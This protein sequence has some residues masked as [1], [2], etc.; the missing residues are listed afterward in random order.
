MRLFHFVKFWSDR[1]RRI[2]FFVNIG[3]GVLIAIFFVI[4]E[5]TSFGEDQLNAAFDLLVRVESRRYADS[6]LDD[7][8]V[9]F[10]DISAQ[11][12]K[13]MGEPLITPRDRLAELVETAWRKGAA[14]IVPDILLEKADASK[15]QGDSRLRALLERMLDENSS[16]EVV[17][18][19]RIGADGYLRACIYDDL[20]DRTTRDGR[21]IFHRAVPYVLA[22]TRDFKNR[23]WDDYRIGL[24]ADKSPQIVWS[25]PLLA[26]A[27]YDRAFP[28]LEHVRRALL[29]DIARSGDHEPSGHGY[30]LELRGARIGVAP[31]VRLENGSV[32]AGDAY[33]L[34]YT[35]RIRFLISPETGQRRDAE[36][37]RPELSPDSLHS[38]IVIIGN[39]SP[40]AGDMLVTPVGTMPGMY[41]Q[42]NAIN[43]IV[44]GR[45]PVHMPGWVHFAIE[46]LIIV[47][48]AWF[49]LHFEATAAQFL[50][51]VIFIFLFG[52][53][54][55]LIYLRWGLFFNFL[56]PVAGMQFH[57][58]AC[59]IE[60][61]VLNKGLKKIH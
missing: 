8:P 61:M 22:S 10:I 35:Q 39:S 47:V 29:S 34:P 38:K 51:S 7:M 58:I 18:P 2:H 31:P 33:C 23:F 9:Y 59:G 15:P 56:I 4:A 30:M 32:D 60:S 5:K 49:F 55:W 40:E 3:V 27:L 42:G 14:V 57:K 17:F 24:G 12:Y 1:Q 45:M 53:I 48:A 37:F 50:T 43:T 6:Y 13:N 41:V 19:V 36:N 16:S 26:S 28:R 25:I 11:E 54:S 44:S 46:G 21:H 52:F 20:I